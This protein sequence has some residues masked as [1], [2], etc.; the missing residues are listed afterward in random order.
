MKNASTH[1]INTFISYAS[2]QAAKPK[3]SSHTAK[4]KLG[5]THQPRVQ[6]VTNCKIQNYFFSTRRRDL[7]RSSTS[8][9]GLIPLRVRA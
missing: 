9:F 1:S 2:Q 4:P 6:V 8:P 7:L 5:A 3:L